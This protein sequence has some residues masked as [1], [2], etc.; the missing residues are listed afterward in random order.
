M[1]PKTCSIVR[2][3]AV[4]VLLTLTSG[5]AS[6]LTC[7]PDPVLELFGV[8]A[9]EKNLSP[10]AIY[11][12]ARIAVDHVIES[13]DVIFEGVLV[14]ATCLPL[15]QRFAL[16]SYESVVWLRG[17]K[18]G[19]TQDKVVGLIEVGPNCIDVGSV[20]PQKRE[21]H[22]GVSPQRSGLPATEV[23]NAELF[24]GLCQMRFERLQSEF[25]G[26][27]KQETKL[28]SLGK[29]IP[30]SVIN[31]GILKKAFDSRMADLRSGRWH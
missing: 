11:T 6:A 26:S 30:E 4:A 18:Q 14:G 12:A 13:A 5:P 15:N 7:G 28:R 2:S 9:D 27:Q 29:S 17:A 16:V 24:V 20:E 22:S 23:Q 1:N 8:L 10:S 25:D 31:W 3:I 19:Q 21:L